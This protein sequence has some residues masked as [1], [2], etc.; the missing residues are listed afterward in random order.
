[1]KTGYAERPWLISGRFPADIDARNIR[2]WWS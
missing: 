1:M 2:R